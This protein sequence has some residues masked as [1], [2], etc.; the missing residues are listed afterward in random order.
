MRPFLRACL[1]LQKQGF[2][3]AFPQC[4][5][6]SSNSS[7]LDIQTHTQKYSRAN[8]TYRDCRAKAARP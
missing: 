6:H 8:E 4:V 5:L 7:S 2:R 3:T 1:Y